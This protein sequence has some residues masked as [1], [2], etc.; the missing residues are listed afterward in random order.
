[1]EASGLT[2]HLSKRFIY[3]VQGRDVRHTGISDASE[4]P[5]DLKHYDATE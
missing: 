2:D 4:I 1:M 3:M 5:S